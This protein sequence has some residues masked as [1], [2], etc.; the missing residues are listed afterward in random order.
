MG[1]DAV[2]MLRSSDEELD[3]H[4]R[5]RLEHTL[6]IHNG[7]V[8]HFLFQWLCKIIILIESRRS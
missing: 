6:P 4:A 1:C 8:R 3:R 7:A 5:H 2:W